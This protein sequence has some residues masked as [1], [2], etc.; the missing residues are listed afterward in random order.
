MGILT[1]ILSNIMKHSIFLFVVLATLSLPTIFVE[2]QTYPR[3]NFAGGVVGGVCTPADTCDQDLPCV[4]GNDR[5]SSVA[6]QRFYAV[7][8]YTFNPP[9]STT[10]TAGVEGGPC[11]TTEPACDFDINDKIGC[12]WHDMTCKPVGT[13]CGT[14]P[15]GTAGCPCASDNS[16]TGSGV[17]VD[18]LCISCTPGDLN[19]VCLP[20]DGANAPSCN[21]GAVCFDDR[22]CVEP[23]RVETPCTAETNATCATTC[24]KQVNL[25]LQR[26]VFIL[27][28]LVTT[29]TRFC[30]QLAH[31]AFFGVACRSVHVLRAEDDGRS[32]AADHCVRANRARAGGAG[33]HHRGVHWRRLAPHF[34]HCRCRL[35]TQK[36]KRRR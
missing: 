34:A 13:A 24:D 12:D 4:T 20:G 28:F 21:N 5:M 35:F 9:A 7:C 3:S 8:Q 26:R 29:K 30:A 36:E 22:V 23:A 31:I 27:L 14:L 17:C 25:I 1:H 19:C 16:C 2:A 6:N 18:G 33:G 11:R 32:V 15:F 10:T